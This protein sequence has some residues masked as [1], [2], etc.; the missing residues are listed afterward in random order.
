[1]PSITTWSA[2][3]GK[4]DDCLPEDGISSDP[5]SREWSVE[6]AAT[7]SEVLQA[8]VQAAAIS[9]INTHLAD[10]KDSYVA[11]V[12]NGCGSDDIVGLQACQEMIDCTD[13]IWD[14][15]GVTNPLNFRGGD[16]RIV[17]AADDILRKIASTSTFY[18]QTSQVNTGNTNGVTNVAYIYKA[19]LPTLSNLRNQ[20]MKKNID[21]AFTENCINSSTACYPFETTFQATVYQTLTKY[22]LCTTGC[23]TYGEFPW[24]LSPIGRGSTT[25]DINFSCNSNGFRAKGDY[26]SLILFCT[27]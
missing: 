25:V 6:P 23:T 20:L 24:P 2:V 3:S 1:M 18:S 11:C 8:A 13:A 10:N 17:D 14:K 19:K 26:E 22:T 9:G 21:V 15:G 7:S 5:F 27:C 16:K 4:E 12:L